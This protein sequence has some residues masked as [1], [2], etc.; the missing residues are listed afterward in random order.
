VST[1]DD[2]ML[3]AAKDGRDVFIVAMRHKTGLVA[4][5]SGQTRLA[6][7]RA[8]AESGLARVMHRPS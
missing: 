4:R 3:A 7:S 2:V 1:S 6:L 8:F 5:L